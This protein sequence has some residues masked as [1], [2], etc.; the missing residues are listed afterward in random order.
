MMGW[1]PWQ[2]YEDDGMAPIFLCGTL[3][4]NKSQISLVGN[5]S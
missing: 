1:N 3:K 4:I 2:A 5:L